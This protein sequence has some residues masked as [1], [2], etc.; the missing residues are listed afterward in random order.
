[1]DTPDELRAEAH[2]ES[3]ASAAMWRGE[4]ADVAEAEPITV[5]AIVCAAKTLSTLRAVAA[6]SGFWGRADNSLT[7]FAR[8][9]QAFG[10]QCADDGEVTA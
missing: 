5:E 8:L 6:Q 9:V 10:Q 4:P 2:R 7:E 3:Q 1:M